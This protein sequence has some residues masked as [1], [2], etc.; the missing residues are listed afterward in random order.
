MMAANVVGTK[1]LLTKTAIEAH[2]LLLYTKNTKHTQVN[3]FPRIKT[4]FAKL[5][6]GC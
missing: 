1:C 2:S 3:W 5:K 4:E 6:G